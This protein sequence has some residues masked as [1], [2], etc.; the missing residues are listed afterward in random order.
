MRHRALILVAAIGGC[1]FE[2][3]GALDGDAAAPTPDAEPDDAPGPDDAPAPDAGPDA[4]PDAP[5][6]PLLCP[7]GYAAINGSSTRY[8]IVEVD[9]TWAAAADDC[10]DDAP[11]G[12]TSFTHLVVVGSRAEQL[13]LA[14]QFSGNTWVGL[15]DLAQEGTFVWVTD[16]PTGG[17]PVV[18][19]QPPWD[20][21]DPDDSAAE[22]CVRFKNS[23]DFEDKRCSDL[24]SYVCECDGFAPRP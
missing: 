4:A 9:V 13:S 15:T 12:G 3:A 22:N 11:S 6:T 16:E 7:A 23:F 18:G 8:R 20:G 24:N 5:E 19:Q 17:F 2:P 21:G 14:N 1:A 10:D